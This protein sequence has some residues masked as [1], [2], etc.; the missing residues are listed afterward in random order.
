V[1]LGSARGWHRTVKGLGLPSGAL[2]KL[3]HRNAERV[4]KLPTR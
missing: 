3:A 1:T 2:E 4:L